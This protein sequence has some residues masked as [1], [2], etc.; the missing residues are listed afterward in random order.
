VGEVYRIAP[1]GMKT[2]IAKGLKAPNG[3]QYNP[4]TGRLFITECFQGNRVFEIDPTGAKE[5]R[6]MIKEDVIPIPERFGFDMNTNDLIIP[7]MG[8]AEFYGFIQI[9][10]KLPLL[11]KS[12]S[13]RWHSKW[14]RTIW[15]T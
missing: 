10:L 1:N 9:Q 3:I 11:Q 14:A 8:T 12:L 7:D 6:L 13:L 2:V 4:R 15:P 5:P